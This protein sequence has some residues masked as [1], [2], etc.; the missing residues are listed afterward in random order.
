M[1]R[2]RHTCINH[3]T[4]WSFATIRILLAVNCLLSLEFCLQKSVVSNCRLIVTQTVR[5]SQSVCRQPVSNCRLPDSLAGSV[6]RQPGSNCRHSHPDCRLPD[7][8][9]DRVRRQPVSNRRLADSVCRQPVTNCR[10]P[11]TQTADWQTTSQSG[12]SRP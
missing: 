1:P 7:S 9:A 5:L 11:V 4:V 6:C 8:L 3:F 12:V 10:L 2:L